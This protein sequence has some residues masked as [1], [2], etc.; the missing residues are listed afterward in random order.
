V[1]PAVEAIS[2]FFPCYND[3]ASIGRMVEVAVVTLARVGV[4]DAEVIVVNDGSTDATAAVG[5][6]FGAHVVAAPPPPS[7]WLGKPWACQVGAE[8]AT[9]T[10]LLFLDAD[11]VLAPDALER[12]VF[13]HATGG[14]LVSVQPFHETGRPVEDLSAIPNTVA[15]MGVGAFAVWPHIVPRAAFG[16]C[17]LTSA[18]DYRR[19]GGHAAVR[20][21]V[22]EDLHL[23]RAY[24]DH[25]LPV[26]CL[27]GGRSVRFRM[28]PDG[29]G[30]LVEGWTKNLAGGAGAANRV[31]VLGAVLWVMALA[32]IGSRGITSV[33]AA[34][35]GRP[36]TAPLV[37]GLL[38]IAAA[39]NLWG[40]VRR[41]GSFR[42]WTAVAFPIPV[43]AFLLIFLR[44]LVLTVVRRQVVWRGRA[45]DLPAGRVT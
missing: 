19:V 21:Q 14:G 29:L 31:A 17:L 27:G 7:G 9:G 26:R 32:A 18:A 1:N 38:W 33:V 2:V 45:I 24:R 4:T 10:M 8:R 28:Y 22:V 20:G 5:V 37:T 11:T 30:Q 39:A 6:R 44:S 23:A 25:D 15:M 12:L 40:M 3:E 35:L 42:W 41:V 43:A 16:P 36:V 34:G 13:E